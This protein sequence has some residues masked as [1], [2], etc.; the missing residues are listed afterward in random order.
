MCYH[1]PMSTSKEIVKRKPGRPRTTGKGHPIMVRLLPALLKP[2]DAWIAGQG[3][4][5]SRPEAIRRIL[6]KHLKDA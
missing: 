3:D 1:E 4:S 6:A 2:L 5:P